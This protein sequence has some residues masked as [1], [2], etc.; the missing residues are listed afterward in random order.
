MAQ[1]RTWIGYRKKYPGLS[2]ILNKHIE[3]VGQREVYLNGVRKGAKDISDQR[4]KQARNPRRHENSEEQ[5]YIP[6]VR[7]SRFE[8]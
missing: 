7:D 1:Y 4:W 2:K 6:T 8:S 3:K 5:K